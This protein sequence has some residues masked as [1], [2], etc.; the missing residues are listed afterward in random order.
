MFRE[1]ALLRGLLIAAVCLPLALFIGYQ[2]ATPEDRSSFFWIGLVFCL[3]LLPFLI[4]WHHPLL[5]IC[6]NLPLILFFLPGQPSVG[7]V[8]AAISLSVSIA[9]RTLNKQRPFISCPSVS[10]PLIFLTAVVLTTAGLTGGIHGNAFGSR[11]LGAS[12]YL[13][14]LG[15]IMGYF[16]LVA[17]PVPPKYAKPLTY[18]FFLSGTVSVF[19]TLIE[20]SGSNFEPLNM[21][22]SNAINNASGELSVVERFTGMAWSAGAFCGFMIMRFGIRGIF[23]VRHPWRWL[24]FIAAFFLGMLGGYRSLIV[25]FFILFMVQ[26]YFEKLFRTRLFFGFVL[27]CFLAGLLILPFAE[28]L[29]LSVQRSISF[30]PVPID[31]VAREDAFTT[32]SWRL[33]MWRMVLAEDVPKYFLLGKGYNF[34]SMDVYLTQMGMAHGIYKAYDQLLVLDDYHNG[35]LTLI[36][37]FGI[38]GVLAFAAFCWGALRALYANYRYGDPAMRLINTFLLADFITILVVFL[39]FYG[40]FYIDLMSFTG[41]IGLSLTLNGGVRRAGQAVIQADVE[42]EVKAPRLQ[43]A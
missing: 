36:V 31:P 32:S 12:R 18:V 6:W 23:D 16:A 11:T 29:P 3:L 41:I 10:F 37:S 9:S 7:I 17:Q 24:S 34:D 14:V 35:P 13:G 27:G 38:F 26:L 25:L 28:Q 43:P 8:M 42:T 33:E 2:L 19:H 30:L 15:A 22:F 21:V 1:S 39:T 5:L 40:E 20:I 4:R